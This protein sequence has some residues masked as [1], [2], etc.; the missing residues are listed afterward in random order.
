MAAK[1]LKFEY[2]DVSKIIYKY[3]IQKLNVPVFFYNSC[4][5]W[6]NKTK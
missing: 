5:T 1:Y 2:E 4:H 6:F 3:G